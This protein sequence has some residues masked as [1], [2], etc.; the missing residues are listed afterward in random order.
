MAVLV[1]SGTYLP[2]GLTVGPT[3]GPG[4]VQEVVCP[5]LLQAAVQGV[6]P[7]PGRPFGGDRPT[8][9]HAAGPVRAHD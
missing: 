7:F 2:R 3:N 9:G 8:A 6:V 4:D 1:A 5:G